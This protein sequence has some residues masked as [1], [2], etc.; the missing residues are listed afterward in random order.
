MPPSGQ[1][2]KRLAPELQLHEVSLNILVPIKSVDD[3]SY[4]ATQ[5]LIN[6]TT[7]SKIDIVSFKLNKI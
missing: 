7:H 6:Y 4:T 5:F 2:K 3:L 1:K